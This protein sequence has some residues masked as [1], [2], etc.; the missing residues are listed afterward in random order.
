MKEQIKI[1][2]VP[3]SRI[4]NLREI[5]EDRVIESN[6]TERS[7][8][9]ELLLKLERG[10]DNRSTAAFVDNLEKPQCCLIMSMFIGTCTEDQY[11]NIILLYVAPTLRGKLNYVN[12]LMKT[13]KAYA[14]TNGATSLVGTSWLYRGSKSTELFWKKHGF[15][16]QEKIFVLHLTD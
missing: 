4:G 12:A 5:F 14:T 9:N 7:D 6:L 16:D 1:L 2:P 11:A 15:E 8:V 3:Q 10:Y 13:A